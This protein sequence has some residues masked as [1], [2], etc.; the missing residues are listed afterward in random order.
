MEEKDLLTIETEFEDSNLDRIVPTATDF[1]TKSDVYLP[2]SD[3][4]KTYTY[5]QDLVD[6]IMLKPKAS[7]G[8]KIGAGLKR[9]GDMVL[10]LGPQMRE[11]IRRSFNGYTM[12][13]MT[14]EQAT[15]ALEAGTRSLLADRQAR[16][17]VE[18]Y[19]GTDDSIITN[20]VGA[21]GSAAILLATGVVAGL[22]TGGAAAT[23]AVG[24]LSGAMATGEASQEYAEK[25]YL[26][27]YGMRGYTGAKDSLWALAHGTIS[28]FIESKLGVENVL[29]ASFSKTGIKQLKR[30]FA[31]NFAESALGEGAEEILQEGSNAL[32]GTL[33]GAEDRTGGEFIHDALTNAAYG[34]AIG[35]VFGSSVYYANR[36][37]L[38]KYFKR[39]GYSDEEA[40]SLATTAL[41]DTKDALMKEIATSSSLQNSIGTPFDTLVGKIENA[42]N[43]AG[44]QE[45]QGGLSVHDYAVVNASDIAGQVLRQA[46]AAKLPVSDILDLSQIEVVDNAIWLKPQNFGTAQDIKA[47]INALDSQI[48]DINTQLKVQRERAKQLTENK[49]LTAKLKADKKEH[50]R[51]KGLLQRLFES[52]IGLDQEHQARQNLQKQRYMLDNY[53]NADQNS[54]DTRV[55]TQAKND[56]KTLRADPQALNGDQLRQKNAAI[57]L[58]A[59][60]DTA[61]LDSLI[62]DNTPNV[63]RGINSAVESLPILMTD[64]KLAS[65]YRKA[66]QM[67]TQAHTQAEFEGTI[68]GA[69]FGS[70]A[71]LHE[72]VFKGDAAPFIQSYEAKKQ[73]NK[74][75]KNKL[76]A[77]DTFNDNDLFY[78]A[79]KE[80][81]PDAFDGDSCTSKALTAVLMTRTEQ[82]PTGQVVQE[83]IPST[84]KQAAIEN[85]QDVQGNLLNNSVE[86]NKENLLNTL[87]QAKYGDVILLTTPQGNFTIWRNL[88]DG[89]A[90][91]NNV[92]LKAA[93]SETMGTPVFYDWLGQLSEKI[94]PL[95]IHF[96][97]NE[98]AEPIFD[99]ASSN[100]VYFQTLSE[101]LDLAAENDRL[102]A[103]NPEYTEATIKI[104]GEIVEPQDAKINY[105]GYRKPVKDILK[106]K[107][108]NDWVANAHKN[109]NLNFAEVSLSQLDVKNLIHKS[110]VRAGMQS[111]EYYVAVYKGKPVYVRK[112]NHWGKFYTNLKIS[113]LLTTQEKANFALS[114]SE[115]VK[116]LNL[117]GFDIDKLN[118]PTE[119]TN[120]QIQTLDSAISEYSFNNFGYGRLGLKEHHWEL[121]GGQR[122]KDGEYANVSQ[123]GMIEIPQEL[124][125]TERTVYNSNGDRIAKSEPALRNFWNWFGD[126]KVVD[127]QGRPLVV[128]HGTPSGDFNTFITDSF[129]TD[130]I[131]Q[132]RGY[133]EIKY[134]TVSPKGQT[135]SVYLK[136]SNPFIYDANGHFWN[137]IDYKGKT[138]DGETLAKKAK[139][140][141]YD[142]VIIQNVKDPA[143]PWSFV[144]NTTDYIVFESTQI[145]S[146]ENRGTFSPDTG[147]IYYQ[148]DLETGYYDAELKVIVLGRNMNTTTL[149]H[150]MAH[151]WID[152]MFEMYKQAQ[153]GD[154]TPDDEWINQTNTLFKI[155]GVESNQSSLT[156]SQQETFATMT[157]AVITGLAPVPNGA[158][159]PITEYLNWVPEKYKSIAQIGFRNENGLIVHPV[160]DK[161]AVDFFNAWYG[162]ISLPALPSSP[163]RDNFT[164]PRDK[165]GE[166]IPSTP[167]TIKRRG[168]IIDSAIKDQQSADQDDINNRT[169]ALSGAI[170]ADMAAS[171][172]QYDSITADKPQLP[173]HE[174]WIKVGRG[175]NTVQQLADAARTYVKKN[176]DHAREIAQ[177]DP[178]HVENDTGVDRESLILAVMEYDNVSFNSDDG[179]LYEHNIALSRSRAGTEL[180]T[181]S[182]SGS[183]QMYLDALAHLKAAMTEQAAY[184]Y[185]GRGADSVAKFNSDVDA[186][187]A[188]WA[189]KVFKDGMDKTVALKSLLA[190][191]EVKFT[192]ENTGKFN[193]LDL[194]RTGKSRQ[195]FI[196]YANKLIK[197]NITQ[198]EPDPVLQAKL[199]D[200]AP[201]AE[202]AATDLNSSDAQ[203]SANA[204]KTLREWGELVRSKDASQSWLS[205]V[206]NAWAP[207]A[208]LSG[209]STHTVSLASN[210][211]EQVMLRPA[212]A[213][214]YGKN[215]IPQEM[216]AA[217]KAR[218]KKVYD[219]TGMNL[220][221]MI[222]SS[223][224][225]LV[226]GEKYKP[227][228]PKSKYKWV[229]PMQY[230][231]MEDNLV[232]VP[233]YVEVLARMASRDS[234]GDI[235]KAKE[236][237]RQYASTQKKKIG[238]V[239]NP[240]YAKRAEVVTV[241]SMA[242]FTQNGKW[243]GALNK[244]RDAL[245]S[246]SVEGRSLQL[247]TMIAP[248]VKTPA[249]IIESG[250]RSPYGAV[251]T[252]VKKLAGKEI[253]AQDAVDTAHF[254]GLTLIGTA[255]ALMCN[256]EPPY[257]RGKYDPNKP[258]DSIEVFPG[259]WIKLDAL[260]VLEAPLRILLSVRDNKI[261]AAIKQTW[262][263]TPLVGELSDGS[264]DYAVKDP[265]GYA[266]GVGYNQI[267][268]LMPT[269][270][271]Q[272]AKP[273]I[274]ETDTTIDA[275]SRIGRKFARR[276]G[277]DD[278]ENTIND[279]IGLIMNRIKVTD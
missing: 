244:M 100:G 274:R 44:W 209:I 20:T 153:R 2:L 134:N 226:H 229:D 219:E 277:L 252:L 273:I 40:A 278:S 160:L 147:N 215:I 204:A 256:Y 11:F 261:G 150:E 250:L 217:E 269:L 25:Y 15:E 84:Q 60:N 223:D 88:L 237:F 169:S 181:H 149:P 247:G 133:S 55:R 85:P 241:A 35:G 240:L 119:L 128:Y 131:N 205:K 224:P 91:S 120:E 94:P 93:D 26:D 105:T 233:T 108:V 77:K 130:D 45:T 139:K 264:L 170:Q 185:A 58:V 43:A 116:E 23:A 110:P 89:W 69:S 81:N 121:E 188:K 83:E 179:R 138:V 220:T 253:S 221:T 200:M 3:A 32:F 143:K 216:I 276:W 56:I 49:E 106:I 210:I 228:N 87:N 172:A 102:D 193:Q 21:V 255:A 101:Q 115:I 213:A 66:M 262:S 198:A 54:F 30:G 148:R 275:K 63:Q 129:F 16:A 7:I 194:T 232:R 53:P 36:A 82:I 67:A 12:P 122:R 214:H 18:Q 146:T 14:E 243:A 145:K 189:D 266:L 125:G 111:S 196:A 51:R 154:I 212:I 199:L 191:A 13:N 114:E 39:Y 197:E 107:A 5:N 164:N 24:V 271:R 48:K 6:S 239:E 70:S 34:A 245:N 195:I 225:S 163:A 65:E 127:E 187:I 180:G 86:I 249:N 207:R 152:N 174:S 208:M 206:I 98:L 140:G 258:Y 167:D 1:T 259:I 46:N 9:T 211:G 272:I 141:G 203:T 230:L 246:L 242:T 96:V 182:K 62:L 72:I 22:T 190:E 260:G 118:N 75:G 270:A 144:K 227:L 19:E 218:V 235:N 50:Q 267:G 8:Q 136:M 90:I 29:K 17:I 41:D 257:E 79:L 175:T 37:K 166:I 64:K 251:K 71:I 265:A 28:G 31:K 61:L 124:F 142:G 201:K 158:T 123:V 238:G 78:Q 151:F 155:L 171:Q 254:I 268:K 113:D 279:Y 234:G 59:G 92:G 73:A 137:T 183:Y 248:F 173:R 157:E 231:S 10:D 80:Q 156:K 126:S 202:K 236:L 97:S 68:D 222:T 52:K 47:Q 162:N 104:G 4:Y 186:L 38:Q 57:A 184:K 192:G 109:Q 176:P 159:L 76:G 168:D 263:A 117:Q 161:A 99:K 27:N 165:N 178:L 135:F 42:L 103:E 132:A 74:D 95:K 112:S 33:A 177:A